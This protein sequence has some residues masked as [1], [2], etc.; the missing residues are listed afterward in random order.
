MTVVGRAS[1]VNTAGYVVELRAGHHD[2]VADEALDLGGTDSGPGPYSLVMAGLAAC[3]AITLRMYA[4]RK[5]WSLRG[6]RV[7][8]TM[9]TG[10]ETGER[11]DRIITLEGDLDDDQRARMAAIAEKTPVTRTLKQGVRI[12]TRVA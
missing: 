10:E 4:D 12:D 9:I 5:T 7:E 8:V 3:T 6:V 2:L 11:I 1:G